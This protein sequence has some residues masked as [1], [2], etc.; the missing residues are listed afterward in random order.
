LHHH[1]VAKI[2][3]EKAYSFVGWAVPTSLY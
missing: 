1:L 2:E 3:A